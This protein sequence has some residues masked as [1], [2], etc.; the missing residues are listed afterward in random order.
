MPRLKVLRKLSHS[1]DPADHPVRVNRREAAELVTHI[2]FP[3]SPRSL[4]V[5]PLTVR[6]VNGHTTVDTAQLFAIAKG[7]LAAADIGTRSTVHYTRISGSRFEGL[8]R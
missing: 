3:V 6:R 8:W 4:E 1:E 7:K 5:W 2:F